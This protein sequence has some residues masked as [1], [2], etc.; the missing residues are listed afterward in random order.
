MKVYK[1][2]MDPRQRPL[3]ILSDDDEA[4]LLPIWVG[5]FEAHAIAIALE[6]IAFPRP[7]TH[8]LMRSLVL[9]L[10]YQL[11]RVEITHFS[12]STYYARLCLAGPGGPLELDARPS[13]AIALALRLEADIF[14]AEEVLT[15]NEFLKEEVEQEELEKFRELLSQVQPEEEE[16][17]EPGPA[18]G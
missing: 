16:G 5:V 3:V 2:G 17:G 15:D 11:E 4:R 14:V 8:D 18:V 9:E 10:G 1:V 6:E 13:D 7:L 12:D